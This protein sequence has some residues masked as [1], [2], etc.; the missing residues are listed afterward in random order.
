LNNLVDTGFTLIDTASGAGADAENV[1][2]V[3]A[4][5]LFIDGSASARTASAFPGRRQAPPLYG[6]RLKRRR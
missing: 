1:E 3:R 5:A 4:V 2:E 6:S